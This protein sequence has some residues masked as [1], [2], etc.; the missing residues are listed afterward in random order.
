MATYNRCSNT[1]QRMWQSQNEA[2]RLLDVTLEGLSD[3]KLYSPTIS[4]PSFT[5]SV[6]DTVDRC[7]DGTFPFSDGRIKGRIRVRWTSPSE[8]TSNCISGFGAGWIEGDYSVFFD[9]EDA[10]DGWAFP[11]VRT[12]YYK[13]APD[14]PVNLEPRYYSM[15]EYLHHS[16]KETSVHHQNFYSPL[17][18]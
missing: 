7:D 14:D 9:W 3:G 17:N 10:E 11:N 5:K 13:H 1:T 16:T 2:K 6:D 18:Q 4:V 12:F 15:M 8:Y